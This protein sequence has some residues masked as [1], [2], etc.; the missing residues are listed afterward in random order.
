MWKA[1]DNPI[2]KAGT[3]KYEFLLQYPDD[4][5]DKYNHW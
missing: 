4:Y 5:S 3:N 2:F 1:L